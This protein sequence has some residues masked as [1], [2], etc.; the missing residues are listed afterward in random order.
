MN[1]KRL[2]KLAPL[3]RRRDLVLT[4]GPAN[5]PLGIISWGSSSGVALEALHLARETGLQVKTLIPRLLYPVP[6]E[7]YRDFFASVKRGVVVEQ[8]HQGQLF[9]LIRMFV[10][11]PAGIEPFARSGSN[12]ISPI[13]I[14]ERL[15]AQARAILE[16]REPVSQAE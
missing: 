11:V 3:A 4:E 8:S 16:D 1:E 2:R 13:E 7:A 10:D 15:R 6:A 9:R 14:V 5:A 12:P